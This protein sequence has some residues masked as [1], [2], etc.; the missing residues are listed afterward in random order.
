MAYP[1]CKENVTPW[2]HEWRQNDKTFD[3]KIETSPRPTERSGDENLDQVNR[4]DFGPFSKAVTRI[5]PSTHL[6]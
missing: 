6:N 4:L 3:G 2:D 5:R 1:V